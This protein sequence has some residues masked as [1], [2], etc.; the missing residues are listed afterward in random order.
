MRDDWRKLLRHFLSFPSHLGGLQH[1]AKASV[2][3]GG[4]GEARTVCGKLLETK[5]T[6]TAFL[7]L[8]GGKRV[9]SSSS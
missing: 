7:Y 9:L 6:V 5:S 8:I 4:W 1:I 2:K 3:V